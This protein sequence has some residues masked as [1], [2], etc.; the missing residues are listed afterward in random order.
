MPLLP[1]IINGIVITN[2]AKE[3]FTKDHEY[4]SYLAPQGRFDIAVQSKVLDIVDCDSTVEL[5]ADFIARQLHKARPDN[6]IKVIGY[7]GVAKGAIVS[8]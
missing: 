4:F 7:E 1:P 5:L 2:K 3:N 6:V 8:V